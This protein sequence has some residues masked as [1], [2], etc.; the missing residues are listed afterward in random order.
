MGRRVLQEIH[1]APS[2]PSVSRTRAS[3]TCPQQV[4]PAA[5]M[6]RLPRLFEMDGVQRCSVCKASFPMQ[7]TTF[8]A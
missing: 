5:M 1:F 8:G 4:R 6:K 3:S 2:G 7:H